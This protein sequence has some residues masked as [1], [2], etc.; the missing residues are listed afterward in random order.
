M[1]RWAIFVRPL[2]GLITKASFMNN[3]GGNRT[4]AVPD[5]NR[6]EREAA[7]EVGMVVQG[8]ITQGQ[9]LRFSVARLATI[10]PGPPNSVVPGPP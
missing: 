9:V 7:N 10:Q 5:Q 1:N 2:R 8:G 6:E 3:P 4:G